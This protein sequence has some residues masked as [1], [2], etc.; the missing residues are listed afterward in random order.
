MREQVVAENVLLFANCMQLP[1][2][3][4]A[5]LSRCVSTRARIVQPSVRL[6]GNR[7]IIGVPLLEKDSPISAVL[8]LNR[9]GRTVH[10]DSQL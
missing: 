5:D 2:Q 10:I 7:Y 9:C 1:R 8:G 6:D 4:G 3:T